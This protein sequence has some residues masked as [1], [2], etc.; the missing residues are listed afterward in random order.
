MTGKKQKKFEKPLT[1]SE[2][3][4][5]AFEHAE[6]PLSLGS[7]LAQLGFEEVETG[8]DDNG[9]PQIVA[10]L[11]CVSDAFAELTALGWKLEFEATE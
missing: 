5:K 7:E 9:R 10:K 11:P 1:G 8:L 3:V 2:I 6:V 4:A